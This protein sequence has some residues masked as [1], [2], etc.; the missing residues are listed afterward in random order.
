MKKT[1]KIFILFSFIGLSSSVMA[2]KKDAN[3]AQTAQ[4]AQPLEK[5]Q[6]PYLGE[7]LQKLIPQNARSDAEHSFCLTMKDQLIQ[8]LIRDIERLRDSF[9]HPE[10][11]ER[12]ELFKQQDPRAFFSIAIK[13]QQGLRAGTQKDLIAGYM[14][15]GKIEI[16]KNYFRIAMNNTEDDTIYVLSADALMRFHIAEGA[17]VEV[18]WDLHNSIAFYLPSYQYFNG[19]GFSGLCEEELS[20]FTMRERL[21][22]ETLVKAPDILET[23]LIEFVLKNNDVDSPVD[24]GTAYI[25]ANLAVKNEFPSALELRELIIERMSPEETQNVLDGVYDF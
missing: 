11:H 14:S 7:L 16:I 23:I 3:E 2:Q 22:F 8:G 24:N 15:P 1:I 9:E 12:R 20:N 18:I 13:S 5:F 10:K 21:F 19:V 6:I 25:W 17:P 4:E